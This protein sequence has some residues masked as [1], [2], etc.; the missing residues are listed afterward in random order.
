MKSYYENI[1]RKIYLSELG[2]FIRKWNYIIALLAG[3]VLFFPFFQF[4]LGFSP[5]RALIYS[6]SVYVLLLILL[7]IFKFVL[8]TVQIF[9]K[10]EEVL[11]GAVESKT[12]T[13]SLMAKAYGIEKIL[14]KEICKIHK[15]GSFDSDCED[16]LLANVNDIRATEAYFEC[17]GQEGAEISIDESTIHVTPT[18]Y[19][20]L[21]IKKIG[22]LGTYEMRFNKEMEPGKEITIS[23]N[24]RGK[25]E[26]F[27]TT[28]QNYQR[29]LSFEYSSLK[30]FYPT[31]YLWL[32][33]HF[34]EEYP[35]SVVTDRPKAVVWYGK[36]KIEH[37]EETE[38]ANENFTFEGKKAILK[39]GSLVHGLE[40]GI[41]WTVGM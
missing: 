21:E 6:F 13:Q 32:E 24:E 15:D 7:C 20:P 23:C 14:M 5:S 4:I 39:L 33:I 35:V 2:K 3:T 18:E 31:R 1:L 9:K 10:P 36:A 11:V 8:I 38:R 27:A 12:M 41:K 28:V 22:E 34:D 26:V 37:N 29:G 30:P 25:G 40:Y 17:L 19:M 16:K